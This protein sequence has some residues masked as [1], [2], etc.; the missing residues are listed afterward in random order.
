MS[1]SFSVKGA[2]AAEAM[3]KVAEA[4]AAAVVSQPAHAADSDE[5]HDA[6]QSFIDLLASDDTQDVAVS[7][8]GSIYTTAAGVQ[9]V[10]VGVS[11]GLVK[12]EPA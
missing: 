5:A 9:Q 12:R 11:A 4:L 2:T 3:E 1:Y 10:S 7:V 8:S 6:A